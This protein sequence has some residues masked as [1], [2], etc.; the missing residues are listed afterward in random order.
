MRGHPPLGAA[1]GRVQALLALQI[2]QRVALALV[3][4]KEQPCC[5][6]TDL[7]WVPG[8]RGTAVMAMGATHRGEEEDV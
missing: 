1:Q 8:R 6:L 2:Q 4:P 3:L 7:L 5:S